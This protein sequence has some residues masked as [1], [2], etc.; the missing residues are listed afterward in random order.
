[1]F[2][3]WI[4]RRAFSKPKKLPSSENSMLPKTESQI[5]ENSKFENLRLL[6]PKHL[7]GWSAI[8]SLTCMVATD[9]MAVVLNIETS[10]LFKVLKNTDSKIR[11]LP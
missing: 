8:P 1:M 11:R 5:L 10:N 6:E 9:K 4:S 2:T 7:L 3:N